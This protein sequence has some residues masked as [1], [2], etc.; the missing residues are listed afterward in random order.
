MASTAIIGTGTWG[1]A[2]AIHLAR[3]GQSCVVWGRDAAKVAE[4]QRTR[5]HP[6]LGDIE[7]GAAVQFTASCDA[8]D[9]ADLILWAVPTQ[10][11]AAIAHIWA[12]RLTAVPVLSLG[13][14]IEEKSLR[15]VSEVLAGEAGCTQ[16]GV[17]SGPSHAEEIA[18]GKS[19]CLVVCGSDAVIALALARLHGPGLRLYSSQDVVGVELAGALKNVVAIA[20][21]ICDGLGCGDNLKAA[22]IT[23]GLA[24]MRRLGRALGANDAT[25]AG[26]AGIGDLMTTCYSPHGRN[27]ALGLALAQGQTLSEH[28]ASRGSVAEGAWTARSARA[29]GDRHGV[30]LPLT[31]EVES[32]LWAAKPVAQALD[33]LLSRSP[34]EENA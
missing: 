15:R 25:F 23:R 9:S 3:N 26:L 21:G 2:M 30:E 6:G 20:T 5:R 7:I 18:Q 17:L 34:K 13:K 29:L 32:V 1:T 14:G 19:A 33:S 8:V 10:H 4:L 16:V 11:T 31:S 24:E 12:G 27:R 28:L 22:L